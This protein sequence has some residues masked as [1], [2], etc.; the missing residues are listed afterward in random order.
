MSRAGSREAIRPVFLARSLGL[1]FVL[2]G[3]VAAS[4]CSQDGVT[5]NCP[6]LPLYTVSADAA[7]DANT[8]DSPASIQARAA[9]LDAGCITAPGSGGSGG[10]SAGGSGGGHAGTSNGG[11]GGTGGATSGGN[12]GTSGASGASGSAGAAGAG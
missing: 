8:A 12:G 3:V 9:A 2:T 6:A 11:H 7:A 10:T 4:A 5:P 1:G